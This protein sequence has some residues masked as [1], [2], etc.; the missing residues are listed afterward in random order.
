MIHTLSESIVEQYI[1]FLTNVLSAS[2]L[3]HSLG[4]MQ[5]MGELV[6]IYDLDRTQALLAGLLHDAAKDLSV[7]RQLALA[8]EAQFE[9][10]HE[11]ERHPVYLHAL[12]GAYLVA[13]ELGIADELILDAISA[14]SDGGDKIGSNLQFQWCLQ[15]ADVLAPVSE[16]PGMKKLRHIVYGGRL[17]EAALLRCHWLLEYFEKAGVPIHPNL[18]KKYRLLTDRLQIAEDFFERW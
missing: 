12:V 2:R 5:V 16:W 4:V 18:A 10:R 15:A 11:C 1:P 6:E 17:D 7:E 3:Q 14:H 13:K 9:F 8:Q